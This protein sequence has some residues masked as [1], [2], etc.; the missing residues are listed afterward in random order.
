PAFLSWHEKSSP[1]AIWMR[2]TLSEQPWKGGS[3]P[4]ETGNGGSGPAAG[5]LIGETED[6]YFVPK[7]D[8]D[9][10][11]DANGDGV[12]DINDLTVIVNQWLTCCQ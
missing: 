5:Y 12:I 9:I 7:G 4:G 1:D 3:N 10:C 8:C 11:E 6:Y 2:I